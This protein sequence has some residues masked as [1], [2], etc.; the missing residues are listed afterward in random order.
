[1]WVVNNQYTYETASGNCLVAAQ[2]R[3][4][5]RATWAR[6]F[7]ALEIPYDRPCVAF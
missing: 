4:F 2:S 5:C 3:L 6:M 7:L 1:M